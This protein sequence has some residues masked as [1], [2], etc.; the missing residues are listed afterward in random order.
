MEGKRHASLFVDGENV[1]NDRKGS[2]SA[3]DKLEWK[4]VT[5]VH[6]AT[7]IPVPLPYSVPFP[8]PA[9]IPVSSTSW[10]V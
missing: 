9:W 3:S 2:E 10:R 1:E 8:T 7:D 5:A 4:T 6:T